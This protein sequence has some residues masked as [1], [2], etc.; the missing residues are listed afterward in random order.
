MKRFGLPTVVLDFSRLLRHVPILECHLNQKSPPSR[1]GRPSSQEQ[2]KFAHRRRMKLERFAD[3][4]VP[5]SPSDGDTG[6]RYMPLSHC[7]NCPTLVPKM[8]YHRPG[9][10]NRKTRLIADAPL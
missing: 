5:Y 6:A 10:G 4:S 2:T 8:E 9:R 3:T 1:F 7:L